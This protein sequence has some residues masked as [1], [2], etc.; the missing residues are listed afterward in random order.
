MKLTGILV[1]ILTAAFYLTGCAM[2]Q[3][4]KP[5][6]HKGHVCYTNAKV[7]RVKNVSEPVK[8]TGP[9]MKPEKKKLCDVVIKTDQGKIITTAQEGLVE[10][11]TE[12]VNQRRMVYI[13][14]DQI[15]KMDHEHDPF[16][17]EQNKVKQ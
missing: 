8:F 11:S 1:L 12:T 14:N 3:S 16:L 6:I 10:C 4:K 2:L 9:G 13:Y 7:I 17:E 5:F 15:I